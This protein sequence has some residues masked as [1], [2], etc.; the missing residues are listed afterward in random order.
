[1]KFY[2]LLILVFLISCDSNRIYNDRTEWA[3]TVKN[4]DSQYVDTL[5]LELADNYYS[6]IYPKIKWYFK[7]K[8]DEIYTMAFGT[9]SAFTENSDEIRIHPPVGGYLD[10]TEMLPYP[11]VH[12]PLK[13]GD[14]YN[15]NHTIGLR[16]KMFGGKEINGTLTVIGKTLYRGDFLTDSC[17][18][19]EGKNTAENYSSRFY[20]HNR[21]GFV[22]FFYQGKNNSIEIDLNFIKYT[23]DG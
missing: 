14:V 19:I 16:N 12:F 11:E 6:A 2:Y 4:S 3:F 15:S 5:T 20:F 22:Y 17:W 21:L 13:I 9:E 7:S 10:F 8:S 23:I 1:M 18:V